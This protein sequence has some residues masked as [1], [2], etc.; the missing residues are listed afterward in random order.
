MFMKNAK[1]RNLTA[2]ILTC[3][4]LVAG[5]A[6]IL[7]AQSKSEPEP[8]GDK[9]SADPEPRREPSASDILEELQK[10]S[11]REAKVIT[12]P[13]GASGQR[14][15]RGPAPVPRG[16][17][18]QAAAARLLPD[19]SRIVD[20][21]GRLTREGDYFTFSFESRGQGAPELPIRLLP[22][23]LLEDMEVISSGGAEPVVFVLSGEVTEYR[24]VN[25]LLIQKLLVRPNLGN[26]K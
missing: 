6:A 1:D 12:M 9:A 16:N 23:R 3:A 19:G 13:K 8:K 21:P 2:L 10:E 24:G 15:V 14:R 26:F 7:Q 17:A 18:I 4:L 5:T 25:Y 20:R 11:R 22:N